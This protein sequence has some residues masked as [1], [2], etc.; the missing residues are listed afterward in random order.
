MDSRTRG[1]RSVRGVT[2]Q[3]G[4]HAQNVLIPSR[5]NFQFFTT[6]C[7]NDEKRMY[8]RERAA[9]RA[10]R[11][12]G[13]NEDAAAEGEG[14]SFQPIEPEDDRGSNSDEESDSSDDD[15]GLEAEEDFD[16]AHDRRSKSPTAIQRDG[17]LARDTGEDEDEDDNVFARGRGVT[18]DE[19][20][21]PQRHRKATSFFK[22]S[23]YRDA[24]CVVTVLN[25]G[26]P[27][28]WEALQ[29]PATKI[30]IQRVEEGPSGMGGDLA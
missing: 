8:Y 24:G 3:E 30:Q 11:D 13:H 17:R 16:E 1:A 22:P 28:R 27:L 9:E 10:A 23:R 21:R 19:L 14:E 25:A 29:C 2:H 6:S 18:Y 15:D 26:S 5:N 20:P 7:R 4:G 12:D